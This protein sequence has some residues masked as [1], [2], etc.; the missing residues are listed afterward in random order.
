MKNPTKWKMLVPLL[1]G[2]SVSLLLS[3]CGGQEAPLDQP[4]LATNSPNKQGLWRMVEE[5]DGETFYSTVLVEGTGSNVKLTDCS[6]AFES[7][8]MTLSGD[9][10]SGYNHSLAPLTVTNNDS[11]RWNYLSQVR[12][13]EKMDVLAKFN[14]GEFSLRSPLLPNVAATNFV[15]VQFSETDSGE[16]MVL[17]TR[18]L[19][20]SLFITI[21]M[22]DGFREG[23]FA[24]DPHGSGDAMVILA[25]AHWVYTTLSAH[26]EVSTGTLTIKKRG[27][28][29]I[30]GELSGILRNGIT[31]VR[32]TFN[33]ET[34]VR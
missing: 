8:T 25:G 13:F 1:C 21:N 19:G 23:T 4:R 34:P 30:E 17:G 7:D 26:D 31:P 3:G 32:V 6:R 9:N 18:V 2:A 12:R 28:V 33:A 24:I 11:M 29:R 22:K 27:N 5:F 15:C 14:M 20:N 10:Y 16:V